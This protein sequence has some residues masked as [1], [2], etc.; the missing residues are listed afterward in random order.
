MLAARDQENLA[1]AHHAAGAS[2]P[3]NQSTRQFAPKTPG[4]KVPK[5]PFK[6]PL[7]NENGGIGGGKAGKG[8]ENMVTGAKKG[9][10]GDKNA[11]VTPLGM[12]ETL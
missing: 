4:N 3:L 5:T 11:F 10:L 12:V 8:N 2:K 1:H 9:G 7:N 6:I